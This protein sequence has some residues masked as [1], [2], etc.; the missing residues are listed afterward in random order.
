[1]GDVKVDLV[2]IIKN[3]HQTRQQDQFQRSAHIRQVTDEHQFTPVQSL[4]SRFLMVIFKIEPLLEK[5]SIMGAL[6]HILNKS[7]P[8]Y[9]SES[10]LPKKS[11]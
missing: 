9:L 2:E 4:F 8:L 11:L 3:D 7:L 10:N 6:I 5:Y 1:M